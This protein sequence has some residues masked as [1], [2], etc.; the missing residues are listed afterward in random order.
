MYARLEACNLERD[1]YKP[2][3]YKTKPSNRE[4][5][6]DWAALLLDA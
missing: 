3:T 2:C 4:F 6:L 5:T 1:G